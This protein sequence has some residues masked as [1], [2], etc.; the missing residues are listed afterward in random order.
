MEALSPIILR[1]RGE[2]YSYEARRPVDETGLLE[3]MFPKPTQQAAPLL[4]H[5]VRLPP[6]NQKYEDKAPKL[7]AVDH[8]YLRHM[9][10]PPKCTHLVAVDLTFVTVDRDQQRMIVKQFK[11]YSSDGMLDGHLDVRTLHFAVAPWHVP[12]AMTAA[13]F[14]RFDQDGNSIVTFDE[15]LRSLWIFLKGTFDDKLKV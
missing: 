6:V 1:R 7:S 8:K 12:Q 13:L 15:F 5:R 11:Q 9:V 4:T 2:S 3:L 10:R 14:R